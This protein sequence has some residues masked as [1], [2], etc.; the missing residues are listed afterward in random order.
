VITGSNVDPLAVSLISSAVAFA[1]IVSFIA[2]LTIL[3]LYSSM[4]RVSAKFDADIFS[5]DFYAF[6][7]MLLKHNK[8]RYS[9]TI[10]R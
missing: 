10:V 7:S 8:L 9:K 2:L 3:A 1:S 5:G 6:Q 4:P